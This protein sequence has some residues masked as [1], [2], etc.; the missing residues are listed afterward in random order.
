MTNL[1]NRD[2]DKRLHT[3][4]LARGVSVIVMVCVHTLWMYADHNVQADTLF[5]HIMHILGKGTASFLV[6]MG[7]SLALSRRR[8]VKAM[9]IRGVGLLL[10]GYSMN[11]LKFVVPITVFDTM[12]MAFIQAYGWQLPLSSGQLMYL[13]LTGDILQM[14]GLSLLIIGGFKLHCIHRNYV[15]TLASIIA[16]GSGWL[17]TESA[18]W[19]GGYIGELLVGYT[20]QVYFP[21]IPWI[22]AIL[23]GFYLGR[24]KVETQ[25]SAAQLFSHGAR[26]GLV[27]LAFGIAALAL[28]FQ[29]QFGNFFHLSFGGISYLIGLNL[30][31]LYVLNR[32]VTARFMQWAGY[33]LVSYASRHVTSLYILQWVIIC[34]GMGVVGYANL[35]AWHTALLM[36]VMLLL[37]LGIHYS[38]KVALSSVVARLPRRQKPPVPG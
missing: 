5:G 3:L 29:S 25:R 13:T 6:A 2:P 23:A 24:Y 7:V 14:A 18:S 10:L 33:A 22:S 8:S 4:D 11:L 12:P 9:L 21:V 35:S 32:F 20:Y 30:C 19:G 17:R 26:L 31:L 1:Q 36:P 38:G 28:D 37:T 15:L 16:V 34:W 27:A